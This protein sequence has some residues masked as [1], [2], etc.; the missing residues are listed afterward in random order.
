[1]FNNLQNQG[2]TV[3]G[4][5]DKE[6]MMVQ[7][8]PG[9]TASDPY[10]GKNKEDYLSDLTLERQRL[11]GVLESEGITADANYNA[12]TSQFSPQ[13]EAIY[14]TSSDE[15]VQNIYNNGNEAEQD[16]IKNIFK[17]SE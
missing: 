5:E 3:V 4:S 12:Y 7:L 9:S 2:F 11:K 17:N 14:Q 16:Y 1:M 8:A 15:Q 10:E 6:E 13:Y